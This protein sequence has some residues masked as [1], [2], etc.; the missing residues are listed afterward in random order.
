MPGKKR[1]KIL[2]QGACKHACSSGAKTADIFCEQVYAY[3]NK[4]KRL[5]FLAMRLKIANTVHCLASCDSFFFLFAFAKLSPPLVPPV[6]VFLFSVC[7]ERTER[8]ICLADASLRGVSDFL[9]L[10]EARL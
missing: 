3:K 4:K 9:C 2:K 7:E 6:F 10:T 5:A 1:K 8:C